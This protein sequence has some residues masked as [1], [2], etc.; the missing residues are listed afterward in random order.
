MAQT[1]DKFRK[2]LEVAKLKLDEIEEILASG[3][4]EDISGTY[5]QIGEL[6]KRLEK[7]KDATADYLMETGKDLEY[8]RQWTMDHKE[9]ISPFR[10]VRAQIKGKMEEIAYKE[11]ELE[12]EKQLY[13]QHKVNEEQTKL[14]LHQQKEIEEAIFLQNQ[15]EEEWYTKTLEFEKEITGSQ[16]QRMEEAKAGK[17]TTAPQS[18]KL[19]KYTITPFSGDY[20]DWLRFWNQFTVEVD[21]SAI[22]EISKF[23]YLLELVKGKPKEDILG[24]PHTQDGYGEAKRILEQTYGKDIK[25]HKALIKEM[26]ELPVLF[27]IHK[28]VII[29]DFY[30][31]LS[32]VV[33]TLKG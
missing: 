29:H 4:A 15:R 18:V 12:L 6:I 16:L 14:K 11:T 10:K 2:Q 26:E 19:Q 28:I 22:S 1:E 9:D 33:R 21:G 23:N 8:I 20:K 5:E 7:S 27:N 24:L 30:N 25:V 13:I 31:R 32:R 3:N 17:N